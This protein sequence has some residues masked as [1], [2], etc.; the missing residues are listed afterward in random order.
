MAERKI[1]LI[2]IKCFGC[3]LLMSFYWMLFDIC[4]AHTSIHA[5]ISSKIWLKPFVQ[6]YTANAWIAVR[7]SKCIGC[8]ITYHFYAFFIKPDGASCAA[9]DH[10]VFRSLPILYHSLAE[11]SGIWN[12]KI[13]FSRKTQEKTCLV[14]YHE[15]AYDS[16]VYSVQ[17]ATF[18]AKYFSPCAT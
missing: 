16:F 6:W 14:Y 12:E 3:C 18:W 7:K 4:C 10:I 1:K 2:K 9:L 8:K 17:A 5:I 13:E 11:C 15:R